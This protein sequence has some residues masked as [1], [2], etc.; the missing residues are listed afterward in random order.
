MFL[1]KRSLCKPQLRLNVHIIWLHQR[2]LSLC[3]RDMTSC[4]EGHLH[5]ADEPWWTNFDGGVFLVLG[6][7]NIKDKNQ[8]ISENVKVHN[9]TNN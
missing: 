4:S 9:D 6:S 1:P 5:W 7:R 8:N 3:G 2:R